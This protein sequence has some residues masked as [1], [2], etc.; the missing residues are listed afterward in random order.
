MNQRMAVVIS[1]LVLALGA[2][3]C[4]ET[5]PTATDPM[6]SGTTPASRPSAMDTLAEKPTVSVTK[7]STVRDI[8]ISDLP[9]EMRLE[10][11]RLGINEDEGKC[12]DTIVYDWLNGPETSRDET[13]RVA[14]LG[15]AVT[16]CVDQS[17][18]AKLITN[19]VRVT[20]PSLTVA[21]ADC[22]EAEI[23]NSD[24]EAL[25]VFLGAFTYGGSGVPEL[26][27]PFITSFTT[28][29]ELG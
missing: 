22:I 12:V 19:Q 29:C 17:R 16:A 15:S 14:A 8:P 27:L 4:G 7:P 18:V 20:T 26:Q 23:A 2:G 1:V 6:A 11:G 3:A 28:A 13:I 9:D 25:A 21:Q 24:P 10:D 5:T